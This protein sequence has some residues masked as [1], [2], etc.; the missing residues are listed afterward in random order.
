MTFLIA[1]SFSASLARLTPDEQASAKATAF[2]LQQDRTRAGMSYHA[3]GKAKDPRFASVRVNDD[4]RVIV[5]RTFESLLLC[6]V[7]HHDDAYRWAERRKLEAHPTTGAMQMVEVRERVENVVKR[8]VVAEAAAWD[9]AP[10]RPLFGHLD[11][12]ALL[13]YGV[14]LEWV[15]DAQVATESTLF[16]LAEHLPAEAADALLTLAVGEVPEIV[17]P[18]P[19]EADPFAHPAAQRRFRVVD[20]VDALATA[21]DA[22][23]E[24]W[25]VFLHPS[26]RDLVERDFGGP[27][28]VSGSA[29]TGK[30]VVALHRAVHLAERDEHAR[31]LL[32]TFSDALARHLDTK[33]RVLTRHRPRLRERIDVATLAGLAAR[34]HR[35]R[36]GRDAK[37]ADPPALAAVLADAASAAEAPFAPGFLATE[38]DQVVDARQLRTWDAY[39]SVP[40]LGRKVRL[41]ESARARAWAVFER[42]WT[43]LDALDLTTEATVYQGLAGAYASGG[44]APYGHVVLDEAQDA[45][46][47]QLR[48]LAQLVGDRPNGLFFAGDL[49]QRIFQQPFSWLSV[50]VDVRGRA[51]TLKVNYRT[52]HQI[53]TRADRL[54][55]ARSDDVDGETQERRGT[56]SVFDGVEPRVERFADADVEARS[57]GAWLRG[58]VEAGVLPHEVGVFVRHE[59]LLERAHAA[60]ARAG[61][62]A[63]VLDGDANP[64]EGQVAVATMHRAKGLE[65]R[66]VAVMACDEDVLPLAERLATASD[67]NELQEVHETERHL[68]Y[69]AATR[70]RDELWVSGVAPGSDYLADL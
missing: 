43:E 23:W 40:R 5:H 22:P 56:I 63:A 54:L 65:Y 66:A 6:Y 24:Q 39:R 3:L 62:E 15:P 57:V 67:M 31:V 48:F 9:A 41:P 70:A 11:E 50:G 61:L 32:A 28:R 53:R 58:R 55:D 4:L 60:V 16:D 29:G 30:T 17:P 49:G 47:A 64:P 44:T 52:S 8:V 69:V 42:V 68:L 45:S 35:A 19:P 7:G 46:A 59:G 34:L 26:Q 13:A 27:A 51:R 18:A 14:P 36:F 10:E 37:V 2:D 1:D 21:L 12:A 25:A 33:L 20:D 38:W